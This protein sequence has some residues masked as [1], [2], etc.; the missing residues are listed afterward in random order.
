MV[1]IISQR[2][3]DVV[4]RMPKLQV[5]QSQGERPLILRVPPAHSPCSI[6]GLHTTLGGQ[7]IVANSQF[8]QARIGALT[9]KAGKR[10]IL[11]AM[12]D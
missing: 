7:C 11:V 2:Q 1:A 10:H 9:Y 8:N 3:L 5:Y 4:G 6:P 12:I